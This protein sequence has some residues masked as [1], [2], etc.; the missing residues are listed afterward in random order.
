MGLWRWLSGKKCLLFEHE[1][2]SPIPSTLIGVEAHA[3]NPEPVEGREQ[4]QTDPKGSQ[5]G[6]PS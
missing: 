6:Q 5:A 2:L 4:K 3:G 1:D